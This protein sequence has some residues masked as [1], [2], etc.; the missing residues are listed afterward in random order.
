MF[1][2]HD[3]FIFCCWSFYHII[4]FI[5]RKTKH[6]RRCS[7]KSSTIYIVRFIEIVLKERKILYDQF[8]Q[9]PKFDHS[10]PCPFWKEKV[11][12]ENKWSYGNCKA[13]HTS[14]CG[15]FCLFNTKLLRD[16]KLKSKKAL[17]LSVGDYHE[18]ETF[19]YISKKSETIGQSNGL[20]I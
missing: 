7:M 19:L 12:L 8:L 15:I 14:S 16:E 2:I 9:R 11:Q 13:F 5:K 20:H 17:D 18:N 1:L 6:T 4:C 3:E 10:K